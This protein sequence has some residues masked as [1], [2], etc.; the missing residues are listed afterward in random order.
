MLTPM[1]RVVGV[2]MGG[3]KTAIWVW[4][5]ST[6]N[7]VGE[8]RFAT[9][10]QAGADELLGE[11]CTEIRSLLDQ[12]GT[13]R[14][15]LLGI[16]VAVPGRVDVK[17]RVL[18]GGCI[19]GWRGLPLRDVLRRKL[20]V[21]VFVEQDANAAA[22]GEQWRG[23]A[24]RLRDFVFLALGTGVGAGVVLG[25]ELHRGAH[26][27]AGE[28]G[29]LGPPDGNRLSSVVGGAVIRNRVE[30]TVGRRLGTSESLHYARGHPELE[31][32]LRQVFDHVALAVSAVASLLDPEAVILGG[33]TAAAG[34]LLL[35]EVKK[36]V[37][38]A[39]RVVPEI[40]LSALGES[41]QLY[42]AICGAL[43]T[44]EMHR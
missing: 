31:P 11:L 3:T 33:G 29:D 30:K 10:C 23:S 38:S 44:W 4:D 15:S 41:A 40:K 25:G 12:T 24:Q 17:G 19:P 32:V 21:P 9:R 43:K 8:R 5:G 22:M 20:E 42:G 13:G 7:V 14:H 34:E 28:L 35:Y 2:D 16:G 6:E 39:L 18:D 1:G 37:E 27:A 26:C 36:R